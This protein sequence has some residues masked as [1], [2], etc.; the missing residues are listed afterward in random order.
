MGLL[1]SEESVVPARDPLPA[2]NA[3]AL[4]MARNK[5]I[6]HFL[7]ARWGGQASIRSLKWSKLHKW[8]AKPNNKLPKKPGVYAFLLV[9]DLP[10]G[11]DATYV[12]YI[13][14]TETQGI[15]KRYVDYV[16][17]A[18]RARG[19]TRIR[20]MFLNWPSHLWYTYALTPRANV[21]SAEK[22][23]RS[24]LIPP[25]NNDISADVNAARKAF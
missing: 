16:R 21:A 3:L 18:G 25:F 20:N 4:S 23:L 17:E 5:A 15:R 22:A 19:R 6:W 13:G 8:K 1:V 12:L 24:A 11:P 10:G 14:M 7:P 9:P 2:T